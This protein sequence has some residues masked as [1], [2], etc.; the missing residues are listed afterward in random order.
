MPTG[1]AIG[2]SSIGGALIGSNASSSAAQ[3]QAQAAQQAMLIQQQQFNTANNAL[4]P[5]YTAGQSALPTLQSLLTP[6][7]SASAL[8]QMPGFKF[9]QQYGNLAAT[10]QLTAEGLGGSAGPLGKAL[11]DYST[12]LAGTYYT[13]STNALQNF[14]N[15]GAGAASALA[16]DAIS[17]GNGQA[18]SAIA[19]GNALASGTLGSANA[20]AG[21][22]TL[23][24][25]LGGSAASSSG[26]IYNNLSN[27]I[28]NGGNFSPFAGSV[29]G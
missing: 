2:A 20:L 4:S 19:G 9:Q 18:S 10:N 25:L 3:Q 28:S 23:S 26:G 17:S 11:T 8:A 5:Y 1:A 16:G 29:F 14:I 24:G 7:S 27:T 15:T 21:G 6:G 12:G 22:L 13:N